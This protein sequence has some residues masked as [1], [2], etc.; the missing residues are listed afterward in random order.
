MTCD[1]E[2]FHNWKDSLPCQGHFCIGIQHLRVQNSSFGPVRK[3]LEIPCCVSLKPQHKR[4][5]MQLSV[6][7]G[8]DLGMN[9]FDVK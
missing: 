2:G 5:R 7:V 8:I 6:G 3:L 4:Q 1:L 9:F